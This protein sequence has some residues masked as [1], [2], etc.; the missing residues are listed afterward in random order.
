MEYNL[1]NYLL[2]DIAAPP[3][4]DADKLEQYESQR[5]KAAS[6]LVRCMGQ[7]NNNNTA[8]INQSNTAVQAV[9]KQ[10]CSTGAQTAVFN[11]WSDRHCPT[12]APAG[13]SDR[14]VRS[15]PG[16]GHTGPAGTG[17]TGPAGTGQTNLSNQLALALVGQCPSN[18]WSN[19]AV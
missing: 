6:I 3:A 13:G 5:G 8:G 16:T 1:D 11:R 2:R 9:L 17:C 7:V 10:P 14:P 18:H 4:S 12:K 19:M 15:A